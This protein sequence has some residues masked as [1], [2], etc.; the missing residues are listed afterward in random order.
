MKQFKDEIYSQPSPK[1]ET[2][3]FFLVGLPGQNI[4]T[5]SHRIMESL[6]LEKTLGIKSKCQFSTIT[7][8]LLGLFLGVNVVFRLRQEGFPLSTFYLLFKASPEYIRPQS[9]FLVSEKISFRVSPPWTR[10]IYPP[11]ETTS[12]LAERSFPGLLLFFLDYTANITYLEQRDKGW[13]ER[14]QPS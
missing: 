11:S 1:K 4:T 6:R 2:N 8:Y 13:F 10:Y 3:L 14:R 9:L 7:K 12:E 5:C